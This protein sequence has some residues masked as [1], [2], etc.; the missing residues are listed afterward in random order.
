MAG[1]SINYDIKYNYFDNSPYGIIAEGSLGMTYVSGGITYN[2]FKKGRSAEIMVFGQNNVPIYNNTFYSEQPI[3]S[4]SFINVVTN[5]QV[6]PSA[7]SLGTKIKN[8]IFYSKHYCTFI[9][10]DAP[11]LADLECDFNIYYVED[12]D[13]KPAFYNSTTSTIISWEDWQALGFDTHSVIINPNFINTT[14]FVPAAPLNYGANLGSAWRNGLSISAVWGTSDPAITTQGSSWQVGSRIH[15][16]P[17]NVSTFKENSELINLF[18]NPND[19]RFSI[20]F[21]ASQQAKENVVT[22]LSLTGKTLSERILPNEEGYKHFD[23]SQLNSGI[24]IMM[25][26]G[27]NIHISKKFIIK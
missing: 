5:T 23:L 11:A 25:I 14:D 4:P 13:H 22:I 19:G 1:Y 12:G 27:N 16:A 9:A 21:L 15:T 3:Y 26:T 6:V 17:D 2:I 7:T 20:D 18:P 10:V 24:Y 8:N